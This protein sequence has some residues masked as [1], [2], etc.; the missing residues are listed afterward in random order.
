[1]LVWSV[2]N[3]RHHP[4]FIEIGWKLGICLFLP[5]LLLFS[6]CED[7]NMYGHIQKFYENNLSVLF[8]QV[9]F[10]ILHFWHLLKNWKK[11]GIGFLFRSLDNILFRRRS[12]TLLFIFP[13]KYSYINMSRLLPLYFGQQFSFIC[14]CTYIERLQFVFCTKPSFVISLPFVVIILSPYTENR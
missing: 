1:M 3:K 4:I 14:V 8:V 2:L 7:N 6:F 9:Y 5:L 13:E 11:C 12:K 10:H